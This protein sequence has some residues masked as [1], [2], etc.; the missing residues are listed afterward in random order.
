MLWLD[1]KH[2][3]YICKKDL[4]LA[5]SMYTLLNAKVD[6][7]SDKVDLVKRLKAAKSEVVFEQDW[8]RMQQDWDNT[9]PGEEWKE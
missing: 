4:V 9:E 6:E 7:F 8:A 2:T 5:Y 1:K 3:V